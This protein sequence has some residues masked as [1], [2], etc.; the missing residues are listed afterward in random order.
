MILYILY[1]YDRIWILLPCLR[2]NFLDLETLT[3]IRNVACS[4]HIHIFITTIIMEA[5]LLSS[6]SL[7]DCLGAE[8]IQGTIAW[9]VWTRTN[10]ATILQWQGTRLTT[11]HPSGWRRRCMAWATGEIPRI[12]LATI[13]AWQWRIRLGIPSKKSLGFG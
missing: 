8:E 3:N 5:S 12:T 4:L 2:I 6:G 9:G 7:L 11:R 13:L 10:L 1:K